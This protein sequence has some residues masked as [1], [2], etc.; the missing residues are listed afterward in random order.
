MPP[1]RKKNKKDSIEIEGRIELAITSL[2]NKETISICE[3]VRLHN[4]PHT[5]LIY[6]LNGRPSYTILRANSHRLTEAAEEILVEWVLSLA[7]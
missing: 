5:T 6:R 7:R 4:V 2:K 3:A 1:I